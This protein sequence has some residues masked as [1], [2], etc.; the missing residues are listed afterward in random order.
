MII[1]IS[2]CIPQQL[3]FNGEHYILFFFFQ[4]SRSTQKTNAQL[5]NRFDNVD[6]YHFLMITFSHASDSLFL[7]WRCRIIFSTN[8]LFTLCFFFLVPHLEVLRVYPWLCSQKSILVEDRTGLAIC[9]ASAVSPA[10]NSLFKECFPKEYSLKL[11][12]SASMCKHMGQML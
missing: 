4:Q 8:T 9:K 2:V 11:F 1:H 6:K 5:T 10:F 12:S 3:D 7:R